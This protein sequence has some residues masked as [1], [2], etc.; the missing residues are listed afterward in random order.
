MGKSYSSDLR[1]RVVAFVEA[2]HSRRAA[3]RHFGVSESFAVKLLQRM[4]RLGSGLP[5]RQGRPPGGGKLAPYA[6]FL[7]G[8]VTAKPDITM[9]ELGARLAAEYGVHAEPATLSR[10]LCQR[11]FTYKKSADGVGMRTRD[12]P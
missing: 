7:V 12:H 4:A 3:A 9:P 2:G 1:D 11:G 10:F 8:A 6:A 5:E